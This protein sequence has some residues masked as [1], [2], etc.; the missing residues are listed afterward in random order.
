MLAKMAVTLDHIS[1]GRLDL[2]IGAGWL[3]TEHEA[4]GFKWERFNIRLQRLKE[5]LEII[6]KLWTENNVTYK[7][8]HLQ[9]K[10]ANLQPKPFQKPHPPLWVGGNSKAII[11]IVAELGDG[12][13]P[14]LPTPRR[15][16]QGASLIKKLIKDFERKDTRL[17]VAFGGSGCT[18]IAK[19]SSKVE[20]LA[21]P[22]VKS[23]RKPMKDLPCIVG[24]PD[25]CI[26]KIKRYQKSGAQKIVAGFFD[27]PSLEG[28]K[29]FAESVIPYFR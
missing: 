7:G 2:G 13:I 28:M 3:K 26:E 27:F 6:R 4:F 23:M 10:N 9:V 1:N 25:Q 16:Q 22:L 8:R 24:T 14:A 5:T 21:E 19:D 18:L 11:H 15:L 20:K 29:L 12:W 17:Q